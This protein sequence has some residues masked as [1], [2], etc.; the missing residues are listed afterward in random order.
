[1]AG[2]EQGG[3]EGGGEEREES[4]EVHEPAIDIF[5]APQHQPSDLPIE[6][7][8]RQ[9]LMERMPARHMR[10]LQRARFHQLLV[11]TSGTGTHHV[12]FVPYALSE[13]IVL[14]IR[15]GQV[16]RFEET[17]KLAAEMIIWPVEHDPKIGQGPVWYPGSGVPSAIQLDSMQLSQ[18]TGWVADMR[19]EQD[20][21][22]ESDRAGELLRAIL[23]VVLMKVDEFGGTAADPALPPAYLALREVLERRL[24]SRSTVAELGAEI[25]YSARTLDRACEAVSGQTAKQVVDERINLELRR[26]LADVSRP[27]ADVREAFGFIDP[28]NF[29]KFVRRRLGRT[30]GD[31]RQDFA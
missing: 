5:F 19:T 29:T 15:P 10:N 14:H 4:K 11:C 23:K 17:P 1:M 22:A 9:E 31:F 7:L 27:M 12:D 13:G 26:L 21:F 20:R 6:I 3:E 8:E 18:V 28:S 30:P 2:E 24:F 16:Q 25:G